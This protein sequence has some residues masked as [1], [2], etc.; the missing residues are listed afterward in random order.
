MIEG[1]G[2]EQ[3]QMDLA[4][5]IATLENFPEIAAGQ[6]ELAIEQA[7]MVLQG[8]AA[9][10]PPAP[11]DSRYRRTGTLGRL[12][13]A[14]QRVVEVAGSG[15]LIGRVGNATP[16]GPLVQDPERQLPFH[17]WRWRTTADVVRDNEAAIGMLLEKA[18]AGIVTQLAQEVAG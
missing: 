18:G 11:A 3:F 10:Y 5:F 1:E 9:D 8:D 13:V 2:F 6:V 14:G 7:L 15:T 12:W 17:A 4:E 16:Y